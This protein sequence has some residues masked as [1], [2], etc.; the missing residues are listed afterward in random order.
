MELI[1]DVLVLFFVLNCAFKLSLWP[2]W[3]R[4]LFSLLLGAFAWWSVR[5]AIL[6]SKTQ[7]ADFLQDTTALQTMAILV[8]VDAAVGFAFCLHWLNRPA[9]T[10]PRSAP[11]SPRLGSR[12]AV[13]PPT[14][15]LLRLYPSLLVFPVV[16]YLLTQTI[17]ANTGVA[18]ETTALGFSLATVILLPLLAEAARWLLPDET[19]RLELHLLLTIFVCIL[20]LVATEHGRM[21][22]AVKESPVDWPSLLLTFALFLS[23]TLLGFLLNRIKWHFKSTSKV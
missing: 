6:Q 16:F 2:L 11:P 3:Q 9:D 7:M 17:F 5:Y 10:V 23:L 18:F 12:S 1:I 14:S 22:Y 19:S 21:V 20:G 13:F 8:T 15:A 4:L